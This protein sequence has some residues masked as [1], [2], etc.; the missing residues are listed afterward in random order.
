VEG[1]LRGGTG[2]GRASR[3]VSGVPPAAPH[4]QRAPARGAKEG[5]H[6]MTA[7]ETRPAAGRIPY[8]GLNLDAK[9]SR[10]ENATGG[11]A[12]SLPARSLRA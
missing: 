9:V 4:S 11:D 7:A 2:S 5:R 12:R 6:S 3:G 10:N 1:C 8:R